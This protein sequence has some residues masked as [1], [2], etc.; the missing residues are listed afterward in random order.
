MTA[1][2]HR[3]LS[4]LCALIGWLIFLLFVI[5]LFLEFN[6]RSCLFLFLF[7][8]LSLS[9]LGVGMNNEW[10]RERFFCEFFF[11]KMLQRYHY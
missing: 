9:L 3:H 8:F 4:S 5:Y 11:R 10:I 6:K 7:L 1:Q 2:R